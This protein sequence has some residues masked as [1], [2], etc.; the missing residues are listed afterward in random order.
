MR[1][2]AE[3]SIGRFL[4]G[5]PVEARPQ[6]L[7]YRSGKLVRRRWLAVSTATVFVIGLAAAAGIALYQARVARI[8]AERADQVNQFLTGMLSSASGFRFDAQ[9]YTVAEM[10]E[11]ASQRLERESGKNPLTE[12]PLRLVWRRAN[13][14]SSGSMHPSA[15]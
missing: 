4:A 8:E 11:G 1:E 10:L 13:T 9:K 2:F 3:A 6:T 5:R 12:G 15:R 7:L 14:P